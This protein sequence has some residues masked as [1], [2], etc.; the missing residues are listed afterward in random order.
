MGRPS[1]ERAQ[2]MVAVVEKELLTVKD[3]A[4]VL[5]V[6]QRQIWKLHS[7]GRLPASVRLARSVRWRRNELERWLSAGCPARDKWETMRGAGA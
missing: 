7:S 4:A 1:S 3:V 6:S 5:S 2:K